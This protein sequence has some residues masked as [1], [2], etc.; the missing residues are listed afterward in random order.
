MYIELSSRTF[1]LMLGISVLMRSISALMPSATC[2]VL[3]PDCFCTR[4]AHARAGR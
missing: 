4:E 2:T 3:V 1:S